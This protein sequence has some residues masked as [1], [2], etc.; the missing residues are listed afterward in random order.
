MSIDERK[1]KILK[2]IIDRYIESAEPVASKHLVEQCNL[3]LSSATIRNEMAELEDLGLLE[4]P[5]TS[6]G[7]I[8]SAL[9]Y[10]LYV[11]RLMQQQRLTSQQ[12]AHINTVLQS[13]LDKFE[14]LLAEAGRLAADITRHA[15]YALPP[16]QGQYERDDVL[17]EGMAHLLE[18]PEFSDIARVRRMVGYLSDKQALAQMPKPAPNRHIEVLIGSENVTAAL[19]DA[20]VVMAT[21]QIGETRGFIGLIGP[22]RMDYGT[23]TSKLGYVARR[24]EHLLSEEDDYE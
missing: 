15:A 18:H 16:T 19:Q 9:G 12:K 1:E 17:V 5:H 7:R 11:D 23:V 20:S 21:Y 22:T 24:L 6:A 13:K 2:I 10:R 4:K 3:E 8:P 14:R